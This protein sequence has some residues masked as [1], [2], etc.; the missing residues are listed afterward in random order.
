M[1]ASLYKFI[2]FVDLLVLNLPYLLSLLL[3]PLKRMLSIMIKN[4]QKRSFEEITQEI[5]S[6]EQKEQKEMKKSTLCFECESED[7][8]INPLIHLLCNHT[9]CE[10]CCKRS[11]TDGYT[12]RV[13]IFCGILQ[14][15]GVNAMFYYPPDDDELF[16]VSMYFKDKTPLKLSD[17]DKNNIENYDSYLS[18]ITIERLYSD[19]VTRFQ[20]IDPIRK[21]EKKKIYEKVLG[22]ERYRNEKD[23]LQ[24]EMLKHRALIFMTIVDPKGKEEC[25]YE[26]E[27]FEDIKADSI[28][29]Y[30][31]LI[32]YRF[33]NQRP[34]SIQSETTDSKFLP[35]DTTSPQNT[36]SHVK[37]I[38]EFTGK[39]TPK[40][41]MPFWFGPFP[42]TE[43]D[44]TVSSVYNICSQYKIPSIKVHSAIFLFQKE[45]Y[46]FISNS[47]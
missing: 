16:D 23:Y 42:I 10:G 17:Y 6:N 3:F 27:E 36:K 18:S 35:L 31:S 4:R 24:K 34:Y 46:L 15:E 44:N 13:C 25:R 39:N 28:T 37:L 19:N 38:K 9:L 33:E 5:S 2:S 11:G 26:R 20:D 43:K 7:S 22:I 40:Q 8:L 45:L 29:R 21:E 41:A 32:L 14:R 30:Q 1:N 12:Y 47:L